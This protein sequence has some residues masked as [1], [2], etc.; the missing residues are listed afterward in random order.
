MPR[1]TVVV[2]PPRPEDAE[3]LRRSPDLVL[4]WA[5]GGMRTRTP[6]EGEATTESVAAALRGQGLPEE[7]IQAMLAVEGAALQSTG[8]I[9]A[10]VEGEQRQ[11][12]AEDALSLAYAVSGG[13]KLLSDL[14][15]EAAPGMALRYQDQY[16]AAIEDSG[17]VAIDFLE[18]FPVLTAAYGYTR[19]DQSLGA[20]SLRWFS[21]E[22]A[23]RVHGY[24]ADTEALLFHLDPLVIARYLHSRGVL[25]TA[26]TNSADARIAILKG[27]ELP[28]AGDEILDPTAGSELLKVVH[29]YAHWI[30]RH[31]AA[32]A[33]IDR[34]SL[35]E[36]L[37]PRHL[38][39]IIY[40]QS[41][42]FVLGGLQ[43]MYEQDLDVALRAILRAERRCALD[44]GCATEG[45]ACVVC[46]HV[47]EPSCRYFNTFLSRDALFGQGG[48]FSHIHR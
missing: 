17:L 48:F 26:P 36:Y 16:P 2:N 14:V 37:V 33:G 46:L 38:A 13:R 47:G 15:D 6:L 20:S 35:S 23:L 21:Q 34:D 32:F 7:T 10:D 12:A 45:G 41:R 44:P 24:R 27:A 19:G 29:S 43:A 4:E 40:A 28:S 31:L 3:A 5:A 18:R 42:G 1:S 11:R 25:P 39:F 9:A 8:E 30:I 22:G